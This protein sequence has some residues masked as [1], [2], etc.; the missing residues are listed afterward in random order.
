MSAPA[1]LPKMV[2]RYLLERHRLGFLDRTSSCSLRS[3]ARHVHAGG[4]RGPLTTE[5]MAEWARRDSHGSGDPQTWA[6]RLKHLRS[7]TRWLQ[8]FEPRTEVPDNAI[9]GSLHERL[10]DRLVV[11]DQPLIHGLGC[12]QDDV[13]RQVASVTSK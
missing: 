11:L 13:H 1:A 9:F 12:W 5:V 3:F 6:R 4:L 8:Q 10:G 7:F 2:E